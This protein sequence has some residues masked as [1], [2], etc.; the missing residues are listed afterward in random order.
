MAH[1]LLRKVPCTGMFLWKNHIFVLYPHKFVVYADDIP[2]T[3]PGDETLA[4]PK[5]KQDHHFE[6]RWGMYVDSFIVKEA[7]RRDDARQGNKLHLIMRSGE[8]FVIP[9]GE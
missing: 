4:Y 1:G 2:N 9:R 5:L 7:D 3:R 8:G 6:R